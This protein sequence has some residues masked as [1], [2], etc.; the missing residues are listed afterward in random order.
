[1]SELLCDKLYKTALIDPI[2]ELPSLD[3]L[4]VVTGYAAA[5]MG[6]HHITDMRRLKERSPAVRVICGMA[7]ES[8]I[9]QVSHNGFV[10][11]CGNRSIDFSCRY[12]VQGE[13]VHAKLYVWCSKGLPVIAFAGSANYSQTAF[14]MANKR[15]EV[16]VQCQ[17][18]VAWEFYRRLLPDTVSCTDEGASQSVVGTRRSFV[19]SCDKNAVGVVK[20]V[21]DTT[22]PWYG[23]LKMTSTLLQGRGSS[24][25]AIHTRA[26]LNWGQ[27]AGREKNQA[28]IPIN[29]EGQKSGFFPE[30]GD[31]FTVKTDDGETFQCVRAQDKGKA[32]E[33][34]GSN[35]L[36]GEYFRRRIG[37]PSG[38]FVTAADLKR[39]GRTDVTFYKI[40]DENYFMDFS[41]KK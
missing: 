30:R 26:G 15:R 5:G 10:N 29:S 23:C 22:S 27:R 3:E 20:V 39:Y 32:I 7:K 4:L 19:A 34:Y 33:T 38:A 17:P 2:V 18:K 31:Y 13:A 35:A 21:E 28:Y 12:L 1:M 14:R 37:V 24:K 11:L 8:G 16:L 9:G 36:L 40:D 25:G 6:V 41:V